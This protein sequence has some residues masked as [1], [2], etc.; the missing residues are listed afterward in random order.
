ME[1]KNIL[2]LSPH[3]DDIE[4][5]CGGT[6]SKYKDSNIFVVAFSYAAP[7]DLGDVDMEF[8]KSMDLLGAK[9]YIL[10]LKNRTFDKQ[11]QEILDYL[12]KLNQDN[13]KGY[14]FDLA[15]MRGLQIKSKYA[16][17]FETI[18]FVI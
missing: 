16:E 5:G 15:R 18:K 4:L 6:L 1:F 11:R 12:W 9:H 10:D 8:K 17:A 14:S 7:S 2:A 3:T 13:D